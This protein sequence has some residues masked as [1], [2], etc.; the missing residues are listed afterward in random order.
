MTGKDIVRHITE[1]A[2]LYTDADGN[3]CPAIG[4]KALTFISREQKISV[5]DAE[6][7]ALKNGIV[8]WRYLRNIGTIGLDGQ[9][10]LLQSSVA[11][12]GAGGLG[13]TII[14]LLAR[15]GIG[16]IIIIDN[17]RFTEQNLNRQLMST[18]KNLG[19]YKALMAAKRVAQINS[20]V[21]VTTLLEKLTGENARRLLKGARV[22][23]D[24]LDNLPSRFAVEDA[25][26]SLRIPLVHGTI[27]GFLGQLT[28]IFPEDAGLRCIYGSAGGFPEQGI[29]ARI[30]NPSATPSIIAA[31]QVQ[32]IVKIITGIGKLLRNSLL[33]LDMMEGSAERIELSR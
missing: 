19:K 4:L 25:C 30:G 8:P 3:K 9:L 22:V 16:H 31:W 29:E 7:A 33:L 12:V 5:K 2:E 13:G 15:Q 24:A 6:T 20:A 32:E 27:A 1:S 18:E 23:A 14:E 28:T 21:T 10:K 26:R 17:D 11:V